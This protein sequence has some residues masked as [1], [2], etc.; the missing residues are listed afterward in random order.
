MF[1]PNSMGGQKRLARI[2]RRKKYKRNRIRDAYF[3]YRW[4]RVKQGRGFM[5][6]EDFEQTRIDGP[7]DSRGAYISEWSRPFGRPKYIWMK[8]YSSP[9]K[10]IDRMFEIEAIIESGGI[11]RQKRNTLKKQREVIMDTVELYFGD[12]FALLE[13]KGKKLLVTRPF[14]RR[15][16]SPKQLGTGK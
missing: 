4:R 3:S 11:T 2:I 7:F 10:L 9:G 13:N 15:S 14:L 1:I 12:T 5:K 6:F 16:N 8:K